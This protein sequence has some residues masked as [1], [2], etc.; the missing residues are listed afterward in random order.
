[1]FKN[2]IRDTLNLSTDLQSSSCDI[3]RINSKHKA[4]HEAMWGTFPGGQGDFIK[5]LPLVSQKHTSDYKWVRECN[6]PQP[7]SIVWQNFQLRFVYPKYQQWNNPDYE[8]GRL[9]WMSAQESTY[10]FRHTLWP[11]LEVFSSHSPFF[12]STDKNHQHS[13][14][15][16]TGTHKCVQKRQQKVK[17]SHPVTIVN[18]LFIFVRV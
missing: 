16:P 17:S 9:G 18:D 7:S 2:L 4:K 6:V 3:Y 1:M 14:N 11:T 8:T 12:S 13:Y 5:L 10:T 15:T